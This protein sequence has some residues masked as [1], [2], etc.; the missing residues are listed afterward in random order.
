MAEQI[1][2]VAVTEVSA[3]RALWPLGLSMALSLMGDATLYTV[4]P[5]HPAEAGIALGSVGI[6]LSVNRVIRLATNGPAGWLYDR[7]ADRRLLFLGSL[8]IGALSTA[9]YALASGLPVLFFARLLWGL[10]WSGIWVGGNAIVLEMAPE[11][12][13]GRWVGIYQVWFFF[14]STL[15]LF[16]G[17]VLTDAVGY[18]EG[19][20]IGAGISAIGALAAVAALSDRHGGSHRARVAAQPLARGLGWRAV[21]PAMWA[22]AT[23][24]GTNR[25]VAAG[26][27]SA[28]L[29]LVIQAN[30]GSEF[31]LGAWQIGVASV[32]GG[33]LASRTLISLVGAPFAGMWSDAAGRRWELLAL[34]LG[35]GA[36]GIGLLAAPNVGAVIVATVVGAAAAG[37]I[38]SLAT[39]LAG[40]LAR[41][42]QHGSNLGILYTAGDLG[43]AIGPLAAYAIMPL[44]GL[45]IV[46]IA[47]AALM[48]IVGIWTAIIGRAA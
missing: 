48:V 15:G 3:A 30:V 6:I 24:Y 36:L 26:V 16:G 45:P 29:G 12:Q 4:L 46:Y 44:A 33:L 21:S 23:A 37:S 17:G 34:S 41:E 27:I 20:W 31:Q 25:L 19:L 14:G 43:S 13:R 9:I 11:A 28:T 7:V 8:W 35:L 2:R 18:R 32:T 5:L 10:A 1:E 22:I 39:A 38:Q 47:C 42:K 40:D